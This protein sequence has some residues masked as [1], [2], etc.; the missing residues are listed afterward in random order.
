MRHFPAFLDLAGRPALVVGT[1]ETAQ[2]KAEL[3]ASAGAT[4]PRGTSISTTHC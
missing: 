3:L 1:G 2:R 4:C